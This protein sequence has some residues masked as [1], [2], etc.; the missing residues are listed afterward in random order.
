MKNV[1]MLMSVICVVGVFAIVGNAYGFAWYGFSDLCVDDTYRGN[2]SWIKFQVA[3]GTVVVQCYNVSA[4]NLSRPGIGNAGDGGLET[5][6]A[7][8]PD[9]EKGVNSVDGCIDLAIFDDPEHPDHINPCHTDDNKNKIALKGTAWVSSFA[10]DWQMYKVDPDVDTD[11]NPSNTG[12]D[13]CEWSGELVEDEVTIDGVTYTYLR[14][15]H[16]EPFNCTST[17]DKKINFI[18]TEE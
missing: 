15:A 8:I 16:D 5:V 18:T 6:I 17:S 12:F 7:S 2:D 10:A 3:Q 13:M 14:P 1:K 11:A 9:K 4:N